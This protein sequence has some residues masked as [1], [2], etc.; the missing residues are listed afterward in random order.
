VYVAI[1]G[2]NGRF[3]SRSGMRRV[4][5]A[6]KKKEKQHPRAGSTSAA[7]LE[8]LQLKVERGNKGNYQ[9]ALLGSASDL[10]EGKRVV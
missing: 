2:F 5:S 1:L 7:F 8:S 9:A 10:H 6:K 4:V 3:A